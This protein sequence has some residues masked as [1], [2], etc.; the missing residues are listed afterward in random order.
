MRENP[1][2]APTAGGPTDGAS[3]EASSRRPAHRLPSAL[4][5]VQEILDAA[6]DRRLALF[7]DYDGTLSPIVDH[8]SK[9]VVED[10]MRQAV[11]R[12]AGSCP[13]AIVSGRQ[14]SDV[15]KRVGIEQ[16]GYAGS[17][18]LEVQPP[19]QQ[20]RTHEQAEG[21][22]DTIDDAED[23]LTNRLAD[24]EGAFTERKPL[25]IAVHFR[26]VPEGNKPRVESI[27]VDVLQAHPELREGRGKQV[28]ELLPDLAWTKADAVR[29][30]LDSFETEASGAWPVYVG[31]DVTDEDAFQALSD[32]GVGILVHEPEADER[33]TWADYTLAGPHEVRAFLQVLAGHLEE[34]S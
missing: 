22:V 34:G 21:F 2:Q 15:R 3:E 29:T 30:L 27:V 24:I 28:V 5:A 18:G 8:P 33:S 25:A 12:V 20:A 23:T 26:Q 9:A 11:Q 4:D 17:H 19:G 10:P 14:L 1:D 13:V 6:G 7:L 31:D 32:Q 16:I